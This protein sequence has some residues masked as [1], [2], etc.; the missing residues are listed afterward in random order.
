MTPPE[1]PP[2]I[3]VPLAWVGYEEVPIAYANQFLIQFQPDASFVVGVGQAT[4]PALI[5]TPEQVAQQAAEIEFVPVRT[6]AR[7]AMTEGKLRELIAALEANLANFER[8][9]VNIDPRSGP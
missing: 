2:S 1:N 4:A 6:L 5:G 3:D 7:I 9:K 8:V